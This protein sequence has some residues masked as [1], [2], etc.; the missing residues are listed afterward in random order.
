MSL[1]VV[2]DGSEAQNFGKNFVVKSQDLFLLTSNL[3]HVTLSASVIL[4]SSF[5]FSFLLKPLTH[6]CCQVQK[7]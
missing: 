4:M 1:F 7:K 2:T 6:P 3:K 5:I